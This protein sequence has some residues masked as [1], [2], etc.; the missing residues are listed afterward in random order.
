MKTTDGFELAEVDLELRGEGTIL[1]ARQ[2]GRSDLKLASLRRGDR[3]LVAA[4]RAVAEDLLAQDPT[5]QLLPA[6]ADEVR[7]FVDEEEA[8]FL[9]KS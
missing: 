8:A 2:K 7:L 5:L 4:A 1:G 3:P 9:L 6:L